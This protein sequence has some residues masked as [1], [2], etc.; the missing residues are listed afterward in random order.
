[1]TERGDDAHVSA[2]SNER[3]SSYVHANNAR[4][5]TPVAGQEYTVISL[6]PLW[7]WA[8]LHAGKDVDNRAWSTDRRGRVLIHAWEQR[9]SL[10]EDQALRAELSFLAGI[11]RTVLPATFE[12]GAIV[13][14]VEIIDCVEAA[15]SRWAARGKVHWV[16]RDPCPLSPPLRDVRSDGELFHW[17]Y[18]DENED[19]RAALS[20][21][22]PRGT[23]AHARADS[24]QPA[25]S[26][27]GV[28]FKAL[29]PEAIATA[30]HRARAITPSDPLRPARIATRRKRA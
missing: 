15:P 16:L 5:D 4:G 20:M 28:Q 24:E 13:G 12:R 3:M 22:V 30:L 2:S 8:V 19:E 23:A 11:P 7:A 9:T 21:V 6:H 14:S 25:R 29:D 17:A 10:R 1:M 26:E 27:S 18:P